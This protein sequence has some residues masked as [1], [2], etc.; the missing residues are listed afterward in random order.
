[1]LAMDVLCATAQRNIN[2]LSLVQ[3]MANGTARHQFFSEEQVTHTTLSPTTFEPQHQQQQSP[4]GE[5]HVE[6]GP[7]SKDAAVPIVA[8]KKGTRFKLPASERGSSLPSKKSRE[9]KTRTPHRVNTL[10][11]LGMQPEF[12][13]PYSESV[14]TVEQTIES[15]STATREMATVIEG[16]DVGLN[17]GEQFRARLRMERSA[18][19]SD[20][21]SVCTQSLIENETIPDIQS[22]RSSSNT[23]VD[24][25]SETS[26]DR[27]CSDVIQRAL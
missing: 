9:T 27:S 21:E 14:A 24:L 19:S 25:G 7:L 8:Q 6:P 18:M 1:M 2:V 10:N 20:V 12:Q 5:Q 26:L 15:A 3:F 16:Q 22:S 13:E 23:S 4:K 11:V 17:L